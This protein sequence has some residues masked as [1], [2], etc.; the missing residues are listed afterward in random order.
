M[1]QG[2]PRCYHCQVNYSVAAPGPVGVLQRIAAV[3]RRIIGAPDYD[4]Y[5]KH[6][7]EAHPGDAPLSREE[8]YRAQLE[9]KY[10]RPGSRC[11]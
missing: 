6:V 10:T 4:R 7:C 1:Q 8:F 9:G 11:C 3:V 5:V 2:P